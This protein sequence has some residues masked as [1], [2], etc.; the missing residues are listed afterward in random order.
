MPN[1]VFERANDRAKSGTSPRT[2]RTRAALERVISFG[3]FWSSRLEQEKK[4][5]SLLR[6]HDSGTRRSMPRCSLGRWLEQKVLKVLAIFVRSRDGRFSKPELW[7]L[8]KTVRFRA[9]NS[10]P[11]LR[12]LYFEPLKRQILT[13]HLQ[14][15]GLL[16]CHS[17]KHSLDTCTNSRIQQQ[18]KTPAHM[19]KPS[20]YIL[21][22]VLRM[23]MK[24]GH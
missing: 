23:V 13:V 8:I 6:K 12:A 10:S 15:F 14:T 17:L 1:F 18:P 24:A 9:R 5:S 2:L 16:A 7:A 4:H 20:I 22:H 11:K 21:C 3:L 19:R